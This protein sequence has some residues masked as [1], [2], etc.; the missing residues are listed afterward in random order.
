MRA[1]AAELPTHLTN[2]FRSGR[3]HSPNA[4]RPPST[5]F[6]VGMGGSA[7]AADLARAITTP[8]TELTLEVLRGP[9]LPAAVTHDSLVLL[10]SYSGDTWETLAAYEEAGRREATRIAL[11]AGGELFRRAERDGVLHFHLPPGLPPRAAAGFTLGGLLGLLDPF[12]PET[13]ELRVQKAADRL[14][15]ARRDFV[16]PRGRAARLAKRTA[17]RTPFVYIETGFGAV[18][19]R[20]KTQIEENAKRLAH[21]DE[22]PELLHNAIVGWDT[23]SR[24]SAKDAIVL[25][26]DLPGTPLAMRTAFLYFV[27]LLRRRGVPVERIPVAGANRIEQLIHALGLGDEYSL[28]LAEAAGV[29][30]YRVDAIG[31]MRARVARPRPSAH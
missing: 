30:P 25:W 17:E 31:R 6:A 21:F 19:R 22:I 13:N 4:R 1:L 29:D 20:W 10:V 7:I 16:S 28:F 26:L 11:S 8:E 15:V 12:F 18:A 24:R 2:G 23:I 27:S 3:E 9:N 14:R 5:V